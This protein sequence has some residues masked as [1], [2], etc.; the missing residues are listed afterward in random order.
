MARRKHNRDM[1]RGLKEE[2]P[3]QTPARPS[4]VESPQVQE[5]K[6]QLQV[7]QRMYQNQ[8]SINSHQ[9]DRL[10][11]KDQIILQN[12]NVE[13]TLQNQVNALT[14]ANLKAQREHRKQFNELVET[15]KQ[16]IDNLVKPI[17]EEYNTITA[18]SKLGPGNHQRANK[19][20]DRLEKE[21]NNLWDNH[22]AFVE[23]ATNKERELVAQ[24]AA[25]RRELDE[26]QALLE[27][28]TL[29]D[30]HSNVGIEEEQV[31][32]EDQPQE[33]EVSAEEQQVEKEEKKKERRRRRWFRWWA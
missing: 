22:C 5:L 19:N 21:R 10:R 2:A 11:E 14:E 33:E 18:K 13:K 17:V 3:S 26:K 12:K 6:Q 24:N 15:G 25:L 32:S 4:H 9:Q 30:E 28:A 23:D 8:V 20:L 27:Q 16:T 1:M 31:T 29:A 7:A